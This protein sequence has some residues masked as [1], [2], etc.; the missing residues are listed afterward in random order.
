MFRG[1]TGP[2]MWHVYTAV[3]DDDDDD[4]DDYDNEGRGGGG[5][6][7]SGGSAV[8]ID[9]MEEPRVYDDDDDDDD[10]DD[11]D[12]EEEREKEGDG[13]ASP[14]GGGGGQQ[15]RQGRTRRKRHTMRSP[16]LLDGLT[17]GSDHRHDMPLC[18][19]GEDND[20]GEGRGAVA[21]VVAF[22]GRLDIRDLR[23]VEGYLM[24][25]HGIPPRTRGKKVRGG[26]ST[27][28]TAT[29][30]TTTEAVPVPRAGGGE[31]TVPT[32]DEDRGVGHFD[33]WLEDERRR[34]ARAMLEQL[35]PYR[36]AMDGQDRG[37]GRRTP[38]P[39]LGL[40]PALHRLGSIRRRYRTAHYGAQDQVQEGGGI[41]RL[42]GAKL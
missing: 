28:T 15:G 17:I 7:R 25:R 19:G 36:M 1:R 34:R 27:A 38:T 6:K 29:A 40:D 16:P 24:E 2:G 23:R 20:P 9:G 8:R 37:G 13:T 18:F 12:E 30:E 22:R 3:F 32:R 41:K 42:V 26:R 4:D 11:Y 10:D 14:E 33:P 35:P 5:G 31:M 39:T 21:E